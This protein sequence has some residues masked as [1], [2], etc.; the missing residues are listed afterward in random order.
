MTFHHIY[1]MMSAQE[2]FEL[3]CFTAVYAH[4]SSSDTTGQQYGC[5]WVSFEDWMHG[6]LQVHLHLIGERVWLP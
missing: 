1:E 4:T 2:A 3:A 5:C 6:L